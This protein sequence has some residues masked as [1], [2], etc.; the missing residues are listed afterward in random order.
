MLKS[1]NDCLLA[2]L[3]LCYFSNTKCICFFNMVCIAHA[4]IDNQ[5]KSPELCGIISYRMF[6]KTASRVNPQTGQLSIYYRLVENSRNAL[7][8]IFQR[9][10]MTVGYL[11][12][13][14]TEELHLIAD[15]LNNRIAGQGTLFEANP[16]VCSYM[17]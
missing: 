7:G 1:G 15:G 6:F 14:S 5:R 4:P 17:K 12:D 11:D 2:L 16:K 3:L 8:G 9:T 13:V 10:I